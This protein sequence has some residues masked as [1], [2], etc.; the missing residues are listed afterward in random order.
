MK[1]SSSSL[2]ENTKDRITKKLLGGVGMH[3]IY[4][5]VDMN[6]TKTKQWIITDGTILYPEIFK[7]RDVAQAIQ[8]ILNDMVRNRTIKTSDTP[9]ITLVEAKRALKDE[10]AATIMV[11]DGKCPDGRMWTGERDIGYFACLKCPH[12]RADGHEM[13]DAGRRGRKYQYKWLCGVLIREVMVA[14]KM[15]DR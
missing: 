12:L 14:R 7:K 1:Y 9:A 13:V 8:R 11:E 10:I 2:D 15:A 5:L 4:L 3:T 6:G